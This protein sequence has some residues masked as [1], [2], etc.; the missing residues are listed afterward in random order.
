MIVGALKKFRSGVQKF[1]LYVKKHSLLIK[2]RERRRGVSRTLLAWGFVGYAAVTFDYALRKL[3][4]PGPCALFFQSLSAFSFPVIKCLFDDGWSSIKVVGK[5]S[6]TP[7]HFTV[8]QR[9][10][11]IAIRSTLGIL[12]GALF[13]YSKAFSSVIDNSSI[14]G[15]DALV[16]AFLMWGILKQKIGRRWIWIIIAFL[17][18]LIIIYS[19]LHSFYWI[20]SVKGAFFGLLSVILLAILLLMTSYMVHHDKP[21]TIAFYQCLAGVIYSSLYLAGSF[22]YLLVNKDFD[23]INNYLCYFHLDHLTSLPFLLLCLGGFLYGWALMLFFQALYFTEV[24]ILATLGYFLS[25]IV[26]VLEWFFY[27]TPLSLKDGLSTLFISVGT[28]GLY[29]YEKKSKE[30]EEVFIVPTAESLQE[31]LY[32][33]IVDYNNGKLSKYYYLSY[34]YEFE[35]LIY[36]FPDLIKRTSLKSIHITNHGVFFENMLP[37]LIIE[38]D[39]SFRCPTFEMLNFGEYEPEVAEFLFPILHDGYVILDIGVGIGWY[40]LNFSKKFPKSLIYAFEPIKDLFRILE[41]N[42]IANNTDN[43]KAFNYGIAN[44]SGTKNF[45]YLRNQHEYLKNILQPIEQLC[46][47]KTLHEVVDSLNSNRLDFI[48]QEL[49][50]KEDPFLIDGKS[51]IEKFKPLVMFSLREYWDEELL[52]TFQKDIQILENLGYRKIV[53]GENLK[54]NLVR[55]KHYFFYHIEKHKTLA[56]PKHLDIKFLQ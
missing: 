18:I 40:S 50:V 32:S 2:Y 8:S 54:Q 56:L 12:A 37:K 46:N 16:V 5:V 6:L 4:I 14:F 24:L 11:S 9:R 10:W 51:V 1:S 39:S 30:K 33:T 48:K 41:R 7:Q 19:D 3:G 22:I 43:I 34:I 23:S 20:R 35:K 42:I 25:P 31:N 47:V 44:Q 26:V 21:I 55:E 28:A 45:H 29:R 13:E 52:K 36:S 53:I 15:A 27:Q 49:R 38:D 17:G